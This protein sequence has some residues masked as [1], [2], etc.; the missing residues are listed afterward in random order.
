MAILETIG[1]G[2]L[3]YWAGTGVASG[4]L[5]LA[6]GVVLAAGAIA[7]GD[8]QLASNALA[9]SLAAPGLGVIHEGLALGCDIHTSV[10]AIGRPAAPLVPC[11]DSHHQVCR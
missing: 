9:R 6:R 7:E 11:R 10:C 1:T 5:Q 3:V 8:V 4:A 2:V